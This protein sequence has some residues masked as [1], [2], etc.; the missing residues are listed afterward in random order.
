LPIGRSGGLVLGVEPMALPTWHL[1]AGVE[2]E[3]NAVY[4]VGDASGDLAF[5]GRGAG[6]PP[7]ATAVLS[8]LVDV[9]H[10]TASTWPAPKTVRTRPSAEVPRR[11]L[12]RVAGSAELVRQ[13]DTMLRKKGIEVRSRTTRDSGSEVLAAWLTDAALP[14]ALE[15]VAARLL[16]REPGARVVALGV[17][18]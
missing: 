6:G 12:L 10:G 13:V 14:S 8:D 17:V 4:V 7:T 3:Y 11:H 5:F 16:E 15:A 18:S 1:L 2:E 9:A